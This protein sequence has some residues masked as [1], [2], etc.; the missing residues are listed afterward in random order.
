M[1]K[2]FAASDEVEAGR[3]APL[4]SGKSFELRKSV[5]NHGWCS[6]LSFSTMARSLSGS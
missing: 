2:G 4:S 5:P 1:E 3:T 6:V